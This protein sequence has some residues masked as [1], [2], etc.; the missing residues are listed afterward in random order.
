M[1]TQRYAMTNVV[2]EYLATGKTST[3]VS[4]GA[5]LRN[6]ETAVA[7]YLGKLPETAQVGIAQNS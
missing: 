5:L 7:P 1:R 3:V 6:G 2:T 4:R